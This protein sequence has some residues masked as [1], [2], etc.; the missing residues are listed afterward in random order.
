MGT[1]RPITLPPTPYDATAERPDWLD[2]P[3]GLRAAVAE[4]L[5][6]PIAA[7]TSGRGGFTRGFAAVLTTTTGERAFVKAARLDE[8]A[9]VADWYAREIAIAAALPAGVNAARP[10]WTLTADGYLAICLA[11]ID[12]HIPALPW[13]PDELAATLDSWA[14]AAEALRQPPAELLGLGLPRL[15]EL[16]REDLS[17][18][19]W[20][21]AGTA[22]MPPAPL[23][24]AAR[25]RELVALEAALPGYADATTVTHCDLRVDNVL[26]DPAGTAW[27]CDWNWLCVGAQW[28]DTAILLITAYASGLDAD[29]LFARHPTARDAPADALDA[30]LATIAGYSLSRAASGPTEAS[31]H[32]RGHQRWSG[33]TA[34][35]WLAERRGWSD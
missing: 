15:A 13:R 21:A 23:T 18:W 22:P 32:L 7:A 17:Y 27:L 8:Q 33:E 6:A 9:S 2:L 1:M 5:G 4:R 14:R 35:A 10:R 28:F 24:A 25:L 19:Q 12:G 30:T 3:S 11:A 29:V 20:I 34:L 16:L 26:I 31:S